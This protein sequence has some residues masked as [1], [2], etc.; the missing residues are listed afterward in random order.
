MTP[1]AFASRY[2]GQRITA[3]SG[4]GGECVDL[5]NQWIAE[6]CGLPH[7][8][9]NAVDW[10]QPS[11]LDMRWTVN[12][13]LNAPLPGSLMVWEAVPVLGIGPFG[14][15]ALVLAADNMTLLSFDQ[16][17][18]GERVGALVIH[19]YAGVLGWQTACL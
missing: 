16:N 19:S 14:H 17:W 18:A 13:P 8:F 11:I 3:V 9:R 6:C 15:I 10:A 5:A 12:T 4:L 1:L 2:L 7:V